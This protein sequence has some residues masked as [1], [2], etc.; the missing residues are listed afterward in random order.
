M[1]L[2]FTLVIQAVIVL[3]VLLTVGPLLFAPIM[4]VIELREKSI[5]GARAE[6]ARLLA[7]T[8]AREHELET[9]LEDARRQALAVRA[10]MLADAKAQ[11]RQLLET[12]QQDAAKKLDAARKTLKDSESSVRKQL[13]ASGK[14]LARSVASKLLSREVA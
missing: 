2:D 14:E 1:D 10:K 13:E 9:Q 6:G 11:E 4:D 7:E 3:T 12:A 8:K 5:T